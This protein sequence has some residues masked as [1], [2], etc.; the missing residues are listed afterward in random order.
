VPCE[1]EVYEKSLDPRSD[2]VLIIASDG[3]WCV[4]S[5]DGAVK[6][7]LAASDARAAAKSLVAHALK[8]G[9]PDNVTCLVVRFHTK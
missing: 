1:P 2:A 3:L 6:L 9:S 7:A 4:V 8:H 5:N